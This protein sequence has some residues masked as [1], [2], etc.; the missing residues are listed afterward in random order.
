MKK[1]KK[2]DNIAY[3]FL[4]PSMVGV[5]LFSLG[6]LLMSLFISLTDW[7]FTKGLGNWN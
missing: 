2:N 4:L 6:P 7:N 3:L 5:V 1:A